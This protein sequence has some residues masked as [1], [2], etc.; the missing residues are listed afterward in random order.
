M[1]DSIMVVSHYTAVLDGGSE[2]VDARPCQGDCGWS[3]RDSSI[4]VLHFRW[5]DVL[6]SRMACGIGGGLDLWG[7]DDVDVGGHCMGR[8]CIVVSCTEFE[9]L[10]AIKAGMCQLIAWLVGVF[11]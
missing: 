1:L 5:Y 8:K 6:V 2:D 4:E 10:L 9:A 7:E 3:G 11:V